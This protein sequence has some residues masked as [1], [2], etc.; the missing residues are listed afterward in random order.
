MN[1]TLSAKEAALRE[2]LQGY[3]SIA[4]AFSGGVDSTFLAVFAFETLGPEKV[5]LVNGKSPS[6]APDEADFCKRFAELRGIPLVIVETN[7]LDDENYAKNPANRCYY[8]KTELFQTI[9]PI[10]L[11]R[12]IAVVADG[13]NAEDVDDF[14]P[15]FKAAAEQKVHHPLQEAGLAKEDVREL[16][17]L[18]NLPTWDK[19]A[20][21]CLASRFPYGEAINEEKLVRV[22]SAERAMRDLGFKEFR[23]R[24]HE[25]LARLEMSGDEHQ[26]GFELKGAID[27]A[28]KGLGYLWVT[29]DLTPFSSGSMNAMLNRDD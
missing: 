12:G 24:S 21:A 27:D 26:R 18:M 20:M 1:K 8:C 29:L 16:S 22:A 19:P 23:V 6:L 25:Q 9:R 14:R 28:L 10:A 17:K 15:G 13:S 4:V 2:I 7:E 5:L 3:G 11:D